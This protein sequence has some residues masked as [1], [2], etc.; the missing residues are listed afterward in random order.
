VITFD[1]GHYQEIS[2]SEWLATS[3]TQL[4]AHDFG[5]EEEVFAKFPKQQ[6]HI[7]EG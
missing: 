7:A 4:L 6:V 2:L 5:V 1:S 3:P